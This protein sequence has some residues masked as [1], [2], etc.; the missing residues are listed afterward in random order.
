M[1][2]VGLLSA[3]LLIGASLVALAGRYISLHPS[4]SF[5]LFL[6]TWFIGL[7]ASEFALFWA[8]WLVILGVA[9]VA[10]DGLG[11]PVGWVA[12]ALGAFALAGQLSLVFHAL[13]AGAHVHQVIAEHVAPG[14]SP[15]FPLS[16]LIL[17]P[18]FLFRGGVKHDRNIVFAE[19]GGVRL[20]LD[21]YRPKAGRPEDRRPAI[22]HVHGGGWVWGTRREQGI[23]LLNHLAAN[24]WVGFNIEYRRSPLATHPEGLVDIKSAIA[25]VRDHADELGVDP[26]FVAITGGSA[27]GHLS[28]L[29]ALTSDDPS[30][31]PGFEDSDTSV[32]AAVPFYGVYDLTDPD[33]VQWRYLRSWVIEPLFMKKPFAEHPDL[34]EQ[35]S[36]THRVHPDAPPFL[37]VHGAGDS[38]TSPRD[39]RTF[40]AR[41]AEVSD[42]PVLYA[43]LPFAQHAFDL[44]PSLRT[45][46]VVR[47]VE[48]FLSGAYA[49][50]LEHGDSGEIID[51]AEQR[52]P[53]S[54]VVSAGS[55]G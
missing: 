16:H 13:R 33:E 54:E 29:A 5:H 51:E 55:R 26:G 6:T 40:A 32:A 1:P 21:V 9:T 19:N 10:F 30:L 45:A 44:L 23:A 43:E 8:L 41:L 2:S 34:Y 3:I 46:G 22:I 37:I 15:R 24:G 7:I 35:A 47:A 39:A 48:R 28:A 53:E 12:L 20:K 49:G 4:R 25:W 36:P 42:N 27:G 18:L 38:I 11:T 50:Y 14:R 17:P 52:V 31:Q